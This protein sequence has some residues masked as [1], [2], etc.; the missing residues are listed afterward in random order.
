M[1]DEQISEFTASSAALAIGDL[2]PYVDVSD[3]TDAASGTTKSM[4]PNDLAADP[5]LL[6]K[7]QGT[8]TAKTVAV[9]LTIAELLTKIITGT[10]TAGATQAYTLPTGTLCDAGATFAT[11]TAFDWVLI[12]L[13]AAAADTITVTAGADHTVVGNMIV[14]SVHAT[15]GLLYGSSATFRTRRTAANT[16]VTYRIA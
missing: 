2:I 9:T 3:T 13:S 11:D 12:N 7:S 4:N 14:Q 16:F 15:T 1:A 6:I 8:P 10:H 5:L